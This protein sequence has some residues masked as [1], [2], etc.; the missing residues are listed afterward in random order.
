MLRNRGKT[1]AV[2]EDASGRKWAKIEWEWIQP[3]RDDVNEVAKLASAVDEADTFIFIG[4]SRADHAEENINK[5]LNAW[6]E[7]KKPLIAF[8]ITFTLEAGR[9]KFA[10]LQ[11]HVVQS[12]KYWKQ[13][14]Q[15]ALPWETEGTKWAVASEP[16]SD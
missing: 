15:M 12:G 5:L 16:G 11:T 7:I 8:I 10:T 4:Y 2:I 1:D 3:Y 6:G 9:R 13:R 14:E